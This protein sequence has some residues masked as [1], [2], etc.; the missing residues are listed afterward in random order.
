M[1]GADIEY[2]PRQSQIADELALVRATHARCYDDEGRVV[3]R[4]DVGQALARLEDAL[5]AA[6]LSRQRLRVR[7]LAAD[8][9]AL[10]LALLLDAGIADDAEL[11]T[12]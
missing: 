8:L 3:D 7:R 9:G 4:H 11:P 6:M 10:A 12:P 2:V 5:P 1:S